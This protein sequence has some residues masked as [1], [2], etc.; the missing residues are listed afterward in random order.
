MKSLLARVY[1]VHLSSSRT[2]EHSK[3]KVAETW[4]TKGGNL[5]I[6]LSIFALSGKM[7]FGRYISPKETF[8]RL[9]YKFHSKG[10][11][12]VKQAKLME[13]YQQELKLNQAAKSDTVER[14]REAQARLKTPYLFL[15]YSC[16]TE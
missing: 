4:M 16:N 10:P 15:H 9:S 3:K 8:R 6:D 14:M 13:R 1:Q 7:S 11:G 12:K 5:L 2:G